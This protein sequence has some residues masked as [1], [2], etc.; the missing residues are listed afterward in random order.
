MAAIASGSVRIAGMAR[1]YKQLLHANVN[2]GI[3]IFRPALGLPPAL[4]A[5]PG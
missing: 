2:E 5:C 4:A 3:T 1:A